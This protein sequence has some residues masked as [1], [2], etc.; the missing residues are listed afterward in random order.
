MTSPLEQ[1]IKITGPSIVTANRA[2]DGAVRSRQDDA[3]KLV[4]CVTQIAQ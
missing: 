3:L 2:V 1:K 4:L